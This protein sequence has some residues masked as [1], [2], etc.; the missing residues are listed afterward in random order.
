MVL[1]T[2]AADSKRRFLFSE[3]VLLVPG[4]AV[5]VAVAVVGDDAG[6]PIAFLLVLPMMLPLM[7]LLPLTSTNLDAQSKT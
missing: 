7:M 2:T 1:N 4:V 6:V 3:R 5:A